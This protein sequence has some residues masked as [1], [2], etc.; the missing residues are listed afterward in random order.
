MKDR[1]M[2]LVIL[3]G[4]FLNAHAAEIGG[5]TMPDLLETQNDVYDLVYIPAEGVIAYKNKK[6]HTVT[7]GLR[8]K[9]ALF[10][11]WLCDNPIQQGLKKALLGR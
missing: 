6:P 5:V 10:A 2:L 9:Q 8:F 11:V 4:S 7:T 3:L 1:I